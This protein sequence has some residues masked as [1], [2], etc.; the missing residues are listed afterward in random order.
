MVLVNL[1]SLIATGFIGVLVVQLI[2]F[3]YAVRLQRV[4]LVDAVWGL[5][6]IAI[7]IALQLT[8]SSVNAGV[9]MVDALVGIW[10]VRLSWHIY[11]RF[12]R[13]PKQ[14][15]RYSAILSRWPTK[16]R[17]LQIFVKIF[18]VQAV[19]A[20]VISLPVIVIH[21]YRPDMSL[22]IIIGLVIWLV[23]FACEV[24]ADR[25]LSAFLHEHRGELM[26]SGLWRF[27]RHPNYFGELTMWWGV[28]LMACATPLWWVGLIGA[29]VITYLICFV[30][31]IP[32]AEARGYTKK[33]WQEYR[34]KT[35]VL[36][37]W[38]PR[39]GR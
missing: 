10:G 9:I 12:R 34:R 39:R 28:A 22:L 6:F 2:A 24:V 29:A 32:P 8:H 35:S 17:M 18:L 19:L 3:I 20:T 1:I 11:R 38:P 33:G 31:G 16:Y 7:V 37:P 36:L 21:L 14:D 25:Q 4:D 23:G 27:S 30:S 5:S 15:E 26:K 13:S